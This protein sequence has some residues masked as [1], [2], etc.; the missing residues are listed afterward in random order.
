MKVWLFINFLINLLNSILFSSIHFKAVVLQLGFLDV[1]CYLPRE[2]KMGG[3]FISLKRLRHYFVKFSPGG[4]LKTTEPIL[5]QNTMITMYKM[6]GLF[7]PAAGLPVFLLNKWA[8]SIWKQNEREISKDQN[9][10]NQQLFNLQ[11]LIFPGNL[12]ETCIPQATRIMKIFADSTSGTCSVTV[13]P[14]SV[15][16]V[17]A[18]H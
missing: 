8:N 18:V 10:L 2:G 15:W 9:S 5:C 13:L 3:I 6:T 14:T 4:F 1:L 12:L 16:N 17:S 7:E 11:Q